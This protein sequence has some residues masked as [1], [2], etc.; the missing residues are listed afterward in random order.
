M[1]DQS[2]PTDKMDG[3]EVSTDIKNRHVNTVAIPEKPMSSGNGKNP[4]NSG[5][6]A[7]PDKNKTPLKSED[8]KQKDKGKTRFYVN[9]DIHLTKVEKILFCDCETLPA[10][11]SNEHTQYWAIYTKNSKSPLV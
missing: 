9:W 11:R 8:P 2:K 10:L 1:L 6:G 3:L 4:V 7:L 5:A